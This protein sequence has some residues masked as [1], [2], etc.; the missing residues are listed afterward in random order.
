MSLASNSPRP[1]PDQ[2]EP[3]GGWLVRRIDRPESPLRLKPF[4]IV[5]AMVGVVA[6]G[7]AWVWM[8]GAWPKQVAERT[9]LAG[10]LAFL[11]GVGAFSVV[12]LVGIVAQAVARVSAY[13]LEWSVDGGAIRHDWRLRR[14]WIMALEQAL[15]I[16]TT[17]I[18]LWGLGAFIRQGTM[19][20]LATFL[21]VAAVTFWPFVRHR[22][23]Y[24]RWP[25]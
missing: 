21:L 14:T 24:G 19:L 15:V 1:S 4:L 2:T 18:G 20:G 12:A 22:I 10:V 8:A 6:I 23:R 13:G 17:A 9:A 5:A 11:A 25:Y 7:G 3:L 16:V